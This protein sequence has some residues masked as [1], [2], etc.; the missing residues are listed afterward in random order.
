MILVRNMAFGI[1]FAGDGKWMG[2]D[3]WGVRVIGQK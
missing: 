2:D 1:P 3:G